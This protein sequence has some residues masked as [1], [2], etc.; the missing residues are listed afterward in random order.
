VTDLQKCIKKSPSANEG[1]QLFVSEVSARYARREAAA[2]GHR[3]EV[4]CQWLVTYT[5]AGDVA[6]NIFSLLLLFVGHFAA[7]YHKLNFVTWHY[8]DDAQVR[9]MKRFRAARTFLSLCAIGGILLTGF[10]LVISLFCLVI[11][12]S[13]Y[14]PDPTQKPIPVLPSAA[15]FVAVLLL[16]VAAIKGQR[17]VWKMGEPPNAPAFEDQR[18]RLEK[19]QINS[20]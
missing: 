16:F 3:N 14:N 4:S 8:L 5:N 18:I 13:G 10:V 15:V 20:H 19:I 11:A 12:L 17:R 7:H 6:V 9:S 1:V 2:W